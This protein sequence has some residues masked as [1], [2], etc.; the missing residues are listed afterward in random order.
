MPVRVRQAP[1]EAHP[2]PLMRH[3]RVDGRMHIVREPDAEAAIGFLKNELASL[4]HRRGRL[5]QVLGG[6]T[7][8]YQGRAASTLDS[9]ERLVIVK[10]DGTL[11]V[12]TSLKAKPVN[13]MPPGNT[14]FA[15]DTEAD[16]VV[17]TA[18]RRKPHHEVVKI[19]F[20]DILLLQALP[21]RDSEELVLKR[22]EGDLHRLFFEHPE[23]LEPG[24]VFHRG[25][26][27]TRRGPV[28]LW[29][30]DGDGNRVLVEVKRSKG[31]I[32]EATQLWRYVEMERT[33]R[34]ADDKEAT[35]P[36][37]AVVDDTPDAPP[38]ARNGNA[39]KIRGILACPGVSDK[40]KKMLA[41]HGLEYRAIDWDD[42]LAHLETPRAA[43]QSTLG[44][45]A[46]PGAEATLK[47]AVV[48]QTV[49]TGRK[50]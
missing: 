2:Q 6:C 8:D 22:T 31:G 5:L 1:P 25:E 41:D 33:G 29:G 42:L 34:Y 37:D 4:K 20:H 12:H 48:E 24:L 19:V 15:V 14:E 27:S 10:P 47:D 30:T 16:R 36:D 11:L 44:R 45:F 40:A 9:G 7:V 49:R 35:S 39:P 28:D 18:L 17:L 43:G 32:S 3:G 21:L 38:A 13:W 50:R 23:L 46:A 26:K